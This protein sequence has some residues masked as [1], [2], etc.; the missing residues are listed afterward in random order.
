MGRQNMAHLCPSRSL[1]RLPSLGQETEGR[2]APPVSM[3]PDTRMEETMQDGTQ[4]LPDG[5]GAM[6]SLGLNGPRHAHVGDNAGLHPR[7]RGR[8]APPPIHRAT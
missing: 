3:G 2:W 6:G 7:G 1:A 4:G 8:W 5:R